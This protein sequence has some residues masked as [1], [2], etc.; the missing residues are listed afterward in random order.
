M[1]NVITPSRSKIKRTL[2]P[3]RGLAL[4]TGLYIGHCQLKYYLDRD[5]GKIEDDTCR[6]CNEAAQTAPST[7]R[8]V[9][10]LRACRRRSFLPDET[11]LPHLHNYEGLSEF[12]DFSTVRTCS[13]H[14]QGLSHCGCSWVAVTFCSISAAT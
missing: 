12:E 2:S 9:Y 7:R 14:K 5:R 8:T 11:R 10:V 3:E 4:S 6:L 1:N 13:T